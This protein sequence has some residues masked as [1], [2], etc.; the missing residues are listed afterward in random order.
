METLMYYAV[1]VALALLIFCLA[2]LM[3]RVIVGPTPADRLQALETFTTV[4][5]AIV[6]LLAVLQRAAWLIDIGIALAAFGFIAVLALARYLAE[7][8]VF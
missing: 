4:L 6:I 7:G 3:Y 8:R 1:E 5:I 2:P